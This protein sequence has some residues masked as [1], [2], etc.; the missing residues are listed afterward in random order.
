M[1]ASPPP[2]GGRSVQ[3][4]QAVRAVAG[5]KSE[6]DGRGHASADEDGGQAVAGISGAGTAVFDPEWDSGGGGAERGLLG[7]RGY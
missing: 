7:G 2:E 6:K 4:V 5:Q 3:R 1:G